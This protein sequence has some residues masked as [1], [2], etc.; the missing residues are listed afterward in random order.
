V[1]NLLVE[2]ASMERSSS[3]GSTT[4]VTSEQ[5]TWQS[6]IGNNLLELKTDF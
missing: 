6:G 1:V 5:L 4:V 2:L 3:S